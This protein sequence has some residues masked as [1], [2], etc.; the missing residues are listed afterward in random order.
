MDRVRFSRSR[1]DF[2]RLAAHAGLIFS[3]FS[4]A[5][6]NVRQ[7][8]SHGNVLASKE[9]SYVSFGLSFSAV[10][11]GLPFDFALQPGLVHVAT[12]R[13]SDAGATSNDALLESGPP[14][15][16]AFWQPPLLFEAS[17]L[18]WVAWTSRWIRQGWGNPA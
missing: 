1:S 18:S 3:D 14:L 11:T 12:R 17:A 13:L 15:P 9:S 6:D 10:R 2:R 8:A 7:Q 16:Q 5:P 4:T